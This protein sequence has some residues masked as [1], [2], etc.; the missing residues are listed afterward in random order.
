MLSVP[1]GFQSGM[2]SIEHGIWRVSTPA[3]PS[4]LW[5]VSSRWV[6]MLAQERGQGVMAGGPIEG[7]AVGSRSFK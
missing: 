6:S 2:G 5:P 4:W 3:G 7:A 1:S